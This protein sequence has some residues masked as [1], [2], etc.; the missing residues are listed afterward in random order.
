[1]KQFNSIIE[2]GSFSI[3]TIIFSNE[4]GTPKIEGVGKSNTQGFDGNLVTSFDEFIDSIKK[5][6]VQAEKQSNFIIKDCFILLANKSIKIN[7]FKNSLILNDSI[8]ENNDIRKLSKIKLKPQKDFLQNIHTSHYQINDDL[9]TD[10]PIGLSCKKVSRISLVSM[11]EKKQVDLIENI[12][13]KLQIKIINF[14][15]S[16]TSYFLYLKEKKL[17]KKNLILIDLVLII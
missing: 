15:D 1:M 16:T 7:K 17:S 12:F 6:V 11:I 10:N 5:S 2:I 9:I 8:I 3:K 4:I 14:M 13:Q